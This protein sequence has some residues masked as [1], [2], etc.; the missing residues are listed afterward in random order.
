[1]ATNC[2]RLL[3][4]TCLAALLLAGWCGWAPSAMAEVPK[5]A[6]E[7]FNLIHRRNADIYGVRIESTWQRLEKGKLVEE[8]DQILET[9]DLGGIRIEELGRTHVG[10]AGDDLI[11]ITD[12]V[13]AFNGSEYR[14]LTKTWGVSRK[15]L[16]TPARKASLRKSDPRVVYATIEHEAGGPSAL[17]RTQTPARMADHLFL[18]CLSNT[19]SEGNELRVAPVDGRTGLWE[20]SVDSKDDTFGHKCRAVVDETADLRVVQLDLWDIGRWATRYEVAYAQEEAGWRTASGRCVNLAKASPYTQRFP[21]EVDA[22]DIEGELRFVVAHSR[23]SAAPGDQIALPTLPRGAHVFDDRTNASYVIGRDQEVDMEL[24]RL[25]G[26]GQR[27]A[28]ERR[29]GAVLGFASLRRVQLASLWLLGGVLAG[30]TVAKAPARIVIRLGRRR[31]APP[32]HSSP[33][34]RGR[35]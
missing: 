12:A 18:E 17:K 4:A 6:L 31:R 5:T 19:M 8:W 35:F 20:V 7:W 25:V 16:L 21:Q 26:D 22:A 33:R 28:T 3:N 10:S 1:M 11:A 29:A 30:L 14:E 23:L 32:P 24:R 9:D 34:S 2:G 27:Q 13:Y 15:E